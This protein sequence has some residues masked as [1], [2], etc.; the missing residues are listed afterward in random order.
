MVL[1]SSTNKKNIRVNAVAKNIKNEVD[2]SNSQAKYWA[3]VAENAA[4][5]A[6]IAENSIA[7]I[8]NKITGAAD[9]VLQEIEESKQKAI[10]EIESKGDVGNVP[11]K[12]SQLENDADYLSGKDTIK[13]KNITQEDYNNLAEKD[14]NTLYIIL[15]S[16]LVWGTGLWGTGNWELGD[17][18]LSGD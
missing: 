10:E 15:S 13:V 5:N 16:L 12:V 11:T 1:A 14:S 7:D 4:N 8:Y 9:S 6:G 18:E 3:E 17:G 2:A